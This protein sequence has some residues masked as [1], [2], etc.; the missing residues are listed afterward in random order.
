MSTQRPA[1]ANLGKALREVVKSTQIQKQHLVFWLVIAL[2]FTGLVFVAKYAGGLFASTLD[3]EVNEQISYQSKSYTVAIDIDER[4][5]ASING[6]PS[7]T[8]FR[9]LKNMDELKYKVFDKPKTFIDQMIVRVRFATPIPENA[10]L[11]AFA[12]HGIESSKETRIDEHT[13]E[14]IASGIGPEASYTIAALLPPG[15]V[16]WPWWRQQLA[17]V[18]TM[19]AWAWVS[20]GLALPILTAL[21]LF[22]MFRSR[23]S[24]FFGGEPQAVYDQPPQ[25]LPPA[26][27]GILVNGRISSREIASTLLDLANRGYLTVFN[28]GGGQFSFA[29][30]RSWQGLQS[31]E[32]LLLSQMFDT[33]NYRSTG[34]DVEASVGA[35]LF[36][37]EITKVYV[38]MYDAAT[39]A[40]YF[41][42][43][44]G[45]VH[46]RYR[47]TGFLLFFL[48][49]LAFVAVL[50][51][52]IEPA[53]LTFIFAGV[54]TMA[55]V[56]ILA[57]DSVPLRTRAGEAAK[58]QWLS[59]RNYLN[60]PV[61]FGYVEGTQ[62]VYE[63]YLPYAVA[64]KAESAWAK[65]FQQFPF[66]VP[67]W[68]GSV[69]Q[70][71]AL[72]DF[73]NGLYGI[74]GSIAH[75]FAHSKEPTIH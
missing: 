2:F 62:D 23:V 31:Y 74:V 39:A 34:H 4:G 58:L 37:P 27:A 18:A 25:A 7:Y 11:Q 55:L 30:R 66:K 69:D 26:I 60:V 75:L 28:R 36:S 45:V 50:L 24:S 1:G 49:L 68:Y 42:R 48:G 71:V 61:P 22:V 44:P 19:P 70:N 5:R 29:K 32:S 73:A 57:A 46:Q 13:L 14:Y 67:D 53:Y 9:P 51:F 59:F 41:E 72:E 15:T 10:R 35:K 54:M 17:A 65:R 38:A 16:E 56:I 12:V 33:K 6:K 40:G 47:I 21:M 52:E 20:A 63:H 3:M 8:I 64:L 43:N